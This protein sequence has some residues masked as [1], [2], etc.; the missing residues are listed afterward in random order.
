MPKILRRLLFGALRPSLHRLVP[1]A[2]H[3]GD[4]PLLNLVRRAARGFRQ[5]QNRFKSLQ[6]FRVTAQF[7]QQLFLP[8]G[9]GR[10]AM[11]CLHGRS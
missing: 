3:F 6:Q 5:V 4:Q 10:L 8:L 1:Q 2:P 11:S 7:L 9:I